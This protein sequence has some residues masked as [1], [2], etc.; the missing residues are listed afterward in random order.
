M[1]MPSINAKEMMV[2]ETDKTMYNEVINLSIQ[3]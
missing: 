3:R 2:N 1:E